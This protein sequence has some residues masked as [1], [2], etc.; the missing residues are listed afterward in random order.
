MNIAYKVYRDEPVPCTK[1]D[2]GLA[3][4]TM[5]ELCDVC[6]MI[7]YLEFRYVWNWPLDDVD[8]KRLGLV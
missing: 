7:L 5:D 2:V 4:Y 1:C 8:K 6:H 3:R